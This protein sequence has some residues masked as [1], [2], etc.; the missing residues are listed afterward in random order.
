M[1]KILHSGDWHLDAPFQGRTDAQAAYLRRELLKIPG[2]LAAL[3][4]EWGV[5]SEN[6]V[7]LKEL[8]ACSGAPRST[9]QADRPCR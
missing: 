8:A 1:I 4:K 6:I 5:S 3:C 9:V 7:L 2:K